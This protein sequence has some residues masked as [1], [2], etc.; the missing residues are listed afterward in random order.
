M[1]RNMEE[2][3]NFENDIY[4]EEIK[5]ANKIYKYILTI[6]IFLGATGFL[7]AGIVCNEKL[8][9]NNYYENYKKEIY[10]YKL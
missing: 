6:A 1:Q 4:Y 9:K 7:I 5:E 8:L 2:L 10:I 3:K